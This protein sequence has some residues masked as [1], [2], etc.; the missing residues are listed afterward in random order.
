MKFPQ[1][2]ENST[3]VWF[4]NPASGN[5][6]NGNENMLL[7]RYLLSPVKW[8]MIYSYQNIETKYPQIDERMKKMW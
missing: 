4:S 3:I 6:Y 7:E 5:I 8:H 2:I 1:K